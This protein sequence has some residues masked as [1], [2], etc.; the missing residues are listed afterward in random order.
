VNPFAHQKLADV[1]LPP[2]ALAVPDLSGNEARYLQECIETGFVSS[3]GPFVNRFE[4]MLAEASGARSAVAT[5]AGTT[6]LHATLVALGVGRGDL[7]VLPSYTFVA[8]ANAISHC[9]A[10]PWLFD[11]TQESWTLDASLVET[12]LRSECQ[13]SRTGLRHRA[14]GKRVA[15]I[16]PVF[17]LGLPADMAEIMEL[18]GRFKLPV[19]IDAAAALGSLYEGKRIGELGAL[20]VVSFNGNKTVTA[21]GGGAI[22]GD[23]E[24]ILAHIRHLTTTARQGDAYEHDMVG[25]NYRMTNIAAAVGCAQL[26]RLDHFLARKR[27]IAQRYREDLADLAGV[28]F[29]PERGGRK[30]SDWLSGITLSTPVPAHEDLAPRLVAEGIASRGFWKPLHLQ[31][32]YAGALRGQ[33]PVCEALWRRVLPLPGSS[34]LTEAD[35][36]RVIQ[37]VRDAVSPVP[38]GGVRVS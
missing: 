18:A 8:S 9:G 16:M 12:T 28:G 22:L 3:V 6:A 24:Q 1:T 35:Q 37:A 38:R 5:S 30:S 31:K 33:M 21:G 17:A 32:P 29:F 23:D 26:E 25:F 10:E 2:V 11:I 7:V 34:S 13:S 20:A 36:T 19:V 15:A 27:A 4:K 14:S